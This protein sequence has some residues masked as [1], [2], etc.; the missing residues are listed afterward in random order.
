MEY[1]NEGSTLP[2]PLNIIPA[3]KGV[4]KLVKKIIH[5]IKKK[6]T[7]N[8]TNSNKNAHLNGNHNK[9]LFRVKNKVEIHKYTNENE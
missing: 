6:P 4:Y 1:I 5:R 3:P 8:D 2:P 7:I 9:N